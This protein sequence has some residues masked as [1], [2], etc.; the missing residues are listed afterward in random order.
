MT[1]Q[2]MFSYTEDHIQRLI[3][4]P[5]LFTSVSLSST[6][7]QQNESEKLMS[8]KKKQFRMELHGHLLL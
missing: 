1:E 6:V 2:D 5:S 3:T 7:K 4:T 8:L